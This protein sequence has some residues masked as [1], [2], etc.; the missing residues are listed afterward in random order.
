MRK[1]ITVNIL[2]MRQIFILIKATTHVSFITPLTP[3]GIIYINAVRIFQ[4]HLRPSNRGFS[5]Y[6]VSQPVVKLQHCQQGFTLAGLYPQDYSASAFNTV[7][8]LSGSLEL[9]HLN[10][11]RTPTCSSNIKT[12]LHAHQD[13]H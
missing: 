12:V 13:I 2:T 10:C 3:R 8:P 1:T 5:H 9:L 6:F 4:F 11:I 7:S